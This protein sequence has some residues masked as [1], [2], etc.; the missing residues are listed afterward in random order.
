[1]KRS[2][3][4]CPRCN[5]VPNTI[6]IVGLSPFQKLAYAVV[7][8]WSGNLKKRSHHHYFLAE[9]PLLKGEPVNFDEKLAH[10]LASLVCAK[11]IDL[12]QNPY[13]AQ[14]LKD[15]NIEIDAEAIEAA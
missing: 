15:Q 12:A 13:L 4:R 5:G 6:H 10:E 11:T 2:E 14:F 3:I 1:M 9:I 7:E 8:C